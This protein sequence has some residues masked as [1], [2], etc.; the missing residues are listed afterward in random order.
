M[1][2]A[3]G[4]YGRMGSEVRRV[5]AGDIGWQ[6]LE[7]SA[8]IATC[9]LPALSAT[10]CRHPCSLLLA[11]AHADALERVNSFVIQDVLNIHCYV[12]WAIDVSTG[13]GGMSE[14][15]STL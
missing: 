12:F 8:T 4:I 7:I 10:L 9:G 1:R 13:P 2:R 3:R 14:K 11:A 5:I 15:V 6:I